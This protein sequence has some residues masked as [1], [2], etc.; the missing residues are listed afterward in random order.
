MFLHCAVLRL[1]IGC[2]VEQKALPEI[3]FS[4]MAFVF[5]VIASQKDILENGDAMIII[6]FPESAV[7]DTIIEQCHPPKKLNEPLRCMVKERM[8]KGEKLETTP[9]LSIIM[10][11]CKTL[12]TMTT[13]RA[14]LL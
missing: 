12:P 3:V 9:I 7:T 5:S 10:M 14:L 2:L 11:L 6:S 13:R 4:F 1:A 8:K